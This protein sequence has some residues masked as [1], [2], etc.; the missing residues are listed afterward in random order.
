MKDEK[1]SQWG[2]IDDLG[3]SSIPKRHQNLSGRISYDYKTV[4]LLTRISVIQVLLSL[5]RRTIRFLSFH[6]CRMGS[7]LL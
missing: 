1:D 2:A 6:C 4:I 7:F 3:I 5:K